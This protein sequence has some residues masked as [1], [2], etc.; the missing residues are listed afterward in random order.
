MGDD[1]QL[2]ILDRVT[3]CAQGLL[4]RVQRLARVGAG[5]DQSQRPILDQITVDPADEEGR[6]KGEAVDAGGS[7]AAKQLLGLSAALGAAV[8]SESRSG[9]RPAWPPCVRGSAVTPGTA[10]AAARC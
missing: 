6:G 2:E 10:A 4:E 5:V 7:G 9:P 8:T 3:Q 1:D